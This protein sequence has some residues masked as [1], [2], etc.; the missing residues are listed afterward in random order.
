MHQS[1]F[2]CSHTLRH[3][4]V[5]SKALG[6]QCS[7]NADASLDNHSYLNLRFD[8]D[9]GHSATDDDNCSVG[10]TTTDD[11]YRSACCEPLLITLFNLQ[12]SLFAI[13]NHVLTLWY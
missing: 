3:A 12:L 9:Y 8:I 5:S 6:A 11:S 13:W 1:V 7:D 4:G 2:P 10:P